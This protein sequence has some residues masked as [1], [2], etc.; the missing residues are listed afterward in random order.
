MPRDGSNVYSADW[1]NAAP[2][3]TIESSKQNAMVADFVADANA[4]RPITAGGTGATNAASAR[5]NLGLTLQAFELIETKT[6][7]SSTA[8]MD[9]TGLS[10]YR[11]LRLS[12][13][14][15]P[16]TDNVGIFLRTSTNN[17]VGYD[18]GAAHYSHAAA[19]G[20]I[21]SVSGSGLGSKT[22]G[23]ASA[24]Q[25]SGTV[26]V[27]GLDSNEGMSFDLHIHEFNQTL[28]AKVNG[29]FFTVVE[30]ATIM[31]GVVGG[32]RLENVARD[33]LRILPSTGNIARAFVTLEGIRG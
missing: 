8:T 7:S 18:S 33:A 27:G 32:T 17:G 20:L 4:A 22:A 23:A 16:E 19:R 30:D 21:A 24:I 31:A 15:V 26:S 3:T 6:I 1:V 28:Y 2:N 5:T 12:G 10:A 11:R 25:I 9:F 29:T 14:I 13:Y